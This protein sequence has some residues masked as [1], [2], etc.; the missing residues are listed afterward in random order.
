FL[1]GEVLP[2]RV[3]GLAFLPDSE[4][5]R[6]DEDR[7]VGTRDDADDQR[8]GEVLERRAAEDVEADDRQQRDERRGQRAPDRLP[9]RD[10][11]DRR[12]RRAPHQRDVLA[13]AVE[14]DDRVVDRVAEHGED[15][16][17]GGDGDL[18]PDEGIDPDGDGYVVQHRED[19]GPGELEVEPDRDV[20]RDQEQRD[21][22]PVDRVD[23]YLMPERPGDVLHP[24]LEGSEVALQRLGQRPLLPAL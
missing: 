6:R 21:D 1:L 7:G 19:H 2:P 23:R 9:Q 20:D 22:D 14:D 5:R 13:Y 18:L 15:G 10:V 17:H 12:E 16:R 3:L 24:G 8:E 11:G 4:Q